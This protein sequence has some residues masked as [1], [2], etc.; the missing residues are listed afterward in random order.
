ML[1]W[2]WWVS[3]LQ[4]TG[5]SSVRL[6]LSDVCCDAHTVFC[7]SWL[8]FMCLYNIRFLSMRFS[9]FAFISEWENTDT[10]NFL[11]VATGKQ[12]EKTWC[13]ER[14]MKSKSCLS[15]TWTAK[16]L[17]TFYK[18]KFI[19]VP[20]LIY[21]SSVL[22]AW[23]PGLGTWWVRWSHQDFSSC[24]AT[25]VSRHHCVWVVGFGTKWLITKMMCVC[26]CGL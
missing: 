4:K 20:F 2:A 15:L 21:V 10:H 7:L 14:S 19:I 8:L 6:N 25:L 22:A 18:S 23:V 26:A 11:V 13:S 17:Q 1:S 16:Q 5:L 12:Q 3:Q 9:C 24:E